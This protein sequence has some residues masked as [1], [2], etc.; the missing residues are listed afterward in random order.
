[1]VGIIIFDNEPKAMMVLKGNPSPVNTVFD[2]VVTK[3]VKRF[4]HN[5]SR[6]NATAAKRQ[7]PQPQRIRDKL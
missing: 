5:H 4:I 2:D 3:R 1:M 7:G 6:V